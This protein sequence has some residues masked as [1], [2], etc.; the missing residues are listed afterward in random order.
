MRPKHVAFE[1][2]RNEFLKD[3][4][5]RLRPLTVRLYRHHLMRHYP[6]GRTSIA[7][8]TPRQII[9]QINTL[10]DRPSEKE[11]AHRIGRTFFRWCLQ[12]HLTDR[13]PMEN[14]PSPPLG[15]SR[16]RV[17]SHDELAAVYRTA[18]NGDT[19]FHRLI[20]FLLLLGLRRSEAANLRWAW[21]EEKTCTLTIPGEYTKN[22]RTLLLPY[23]PV[24]SAL[25]EKTPR[26]SEIYLFLATREQ[27]RGKPVTIM[28]GFSKPKTDFD[29]K[30]HVHGWVMHD[31]RRVVAVG[32]QK[33]G[34]RLEVIEALLNHV[35]GTRAGIVGI[36]QRYDYQSE[37]R[38]AVQNWQEHL[39]ALLHITQD[40]DPC[41]RL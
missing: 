30:C 23:G 37:L 40:I 13:S 31:C 17:L 16:E 24:V 39:H 1:D 28:T 36:Y 18:W 41:Q 5:T 38:I 3:C 34:V 20:C 7:D 4:E 2:A 32:L 29:L 15:K 33:L 6:F 9:K 10:N 35:S 19:P 21:F 14:L 8:V 12:Q 25:L 22:K 27:V 11:H 26:L